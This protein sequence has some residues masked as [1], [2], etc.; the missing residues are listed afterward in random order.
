MRFFFSFFILAAT[1]ASTPAP[2]GPNVPLCLAMQNNYNDCVRHQQRR[3]HWENRDG[4]ERPP[5]APPHPRRSHHSADCS[6][7]LIQLKANGC[8]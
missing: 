2:A 4:W 5:W 1:F 8:F 6:V 3:E 7:W